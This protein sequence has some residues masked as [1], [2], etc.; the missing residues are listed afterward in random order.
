MSEMLKSRMEMQELAKQYDIRPIPLPP[1]PPAAPQSRL[2]GGVS[3]SPERDDDFFPTEAQGSPPPS[4]STAG[5][6]DTAAAASSAAA[7]GAPS[8]L[9]DSVIVSMLR[10]EALL[11]KAKLHYLVFEHLQQDKAVRSLKSQ[12]KQVV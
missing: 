6:E 8:P 3:S 4:A 2:E 12:L 9:P 1:T 5:P 10:R 11:T 7:A